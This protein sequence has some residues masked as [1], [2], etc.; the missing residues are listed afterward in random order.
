MRDRLKYY[1]YTL[2][3]IPI[4]LAAFGVVMVYSASMVSAVVEGYES[5]HYLI[6]QSQW[7]FFSLIAFIFCTIF[8][9]QYYQKFIKSIILLSIISLLAVLFFGKSA[10]NATRS[11]VI[12]RSFSLQPAE[13]VKLG[14]ILYLASVYSKKQAYIHD[15]LT[16][17]L[18]P[19]LIIGLLLGLIILQPDI[20][21]TSILLLIAFTIIVSSGIR[22]KHILL[23]TG[24][25]LLF[26]AIAIPNLIT[27]GRISR[28]VGAYRP[29]EIPHDDGYHLIQSYLAIGV[30][31]LKGE[32]L[33][34]SIQKL[35]YLWGA[36]TDFIMSVISEE[37]G[38]IG[39]LTVIGLLTVLVLRGLY[40]ARNCENS[41]GALLAI[42]ISAMIGF[43]SVVNLG[44]ISGLLPITG[45]PLPFISYGG[46]SLLVMMM[47]MGILNNIAMDVKRNEQQPNKV[48]ENITLQ[49]KNYFNIGGRTWHN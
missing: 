27:E 8:P 5:T 33:G 7:F 32:G 28:F 15:F 48:E 11:I 35:G 31:G 39:V 29:F 3:I 42:G 23:L 19:L 12:F 17:V 47:S 14:L 21:T 34:Q 25:G 40:I 43:Q 10:Y 26:L 1:D 24:I 46:S 36:H 49:G 18:P 6:R 41:F 2:I 30:G 44:A 22:P 45:V 4:F 16:G 38:L 9:Y 13:F 37:L 20:G